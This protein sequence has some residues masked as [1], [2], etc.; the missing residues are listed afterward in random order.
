M[1]DV[2]IEDLER[3]GIIGTFDIE[4]VPSAEHR[5]FMYSMEPELTGSHIPREVRLSQTTIVTRCLIWGVWLVAMFVIL[6]LGKQDY[7][8]VQMLPQMRG[9]CLFSWITVALLTSLFL[10]YLITTKERQ[11]KRQI[12]LLREGIAVQAKVT[13]IE[14]MSYCN[15]CV[16]FS[17]GQKIREEL[18]AVSVEQHYSL[19]SGDANHTI[20][21]HST[22]PTDCLLYLQIEAAHLTAVLR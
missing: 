7:Q 19:T 6:T 12:Y 18:I 9:T 16:C 3:H 14:G 20:L 22:A 21:F 13:A 4:D 17:D 11:W 5:T 10:G 2:F 8:A 1:E 15:I